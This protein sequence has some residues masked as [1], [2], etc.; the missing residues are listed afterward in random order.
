M[1]VSKLEKEE[2]LQKAFKQLDKD[3]SGTISIDELAEACKCVA[4]DGWL[5]VCACVRVCVCAR[6]CVRA[7]ACVCVLCV[8]RQVWQGARAMSMRHGHM[9]RGGAGGTPRAASP[10]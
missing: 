6:A 7:R 10:P 1:H 3:G 8:L 4:R 9:W 5:R 2:L